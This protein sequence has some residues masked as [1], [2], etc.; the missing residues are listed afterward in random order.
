MS[1]G[2]PQGV[3]GLKGLSLTTGSDSSTPGP[4]IVSTAEHVKLEY[5]TQLQ[6]RVTGL[7][8]P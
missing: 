2:M 3:F 1:Q 8:A 7:S 4:V 6:V 5:G